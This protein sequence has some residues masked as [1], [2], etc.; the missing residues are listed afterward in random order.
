VASPP[1]LVSA[2]RIA[3]A[4]DGAVALCE[5]VKRN[6]SGELACNERNDERQIAL[7]K[8]GVTL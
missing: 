3:P 8:T 2:L 7:W 4:D 6:A 1:S 5:R